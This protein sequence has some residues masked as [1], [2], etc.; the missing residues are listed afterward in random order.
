VLIKSFLDAEK[1]SAKAILSPE[2][3]A[4]FKEAF[5]L[6]DK[7]GDGSITISELETVMRSLGQTPTKDELAA[8]IKSVDVDGN[9]E[10]DF[11]EFLAMLASKMSETQDELAECFGVFD[12][13]KDG[14]IE[15][16]ELKQVMESLGEKLTNEDIQHMISELDP[17]KTGKVSYDNFLKMAVGQKL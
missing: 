10:I 14:F 3:V 9:G 11:D 15:A 6:F 13:N 8:M 1:A 2:Q 4:E 16:A 5:N 17:E 12:K 7:N